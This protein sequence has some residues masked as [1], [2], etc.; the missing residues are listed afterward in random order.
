MVEASRTAVVGD[1]AR[2]VELAQLLRVELNAM[3]GGELWL[4]REAWPEPL[5]E[6]YAN[7]IDA[8][9]TLVVVGTI[10]DAII[11]YGV[12]VIETLRSSAQLGVITDLFVEPGARAV[13]IGECMALQLIAFC[14]DHGCIGIDAL[15]LPGHREAKNF[16]ER[17]GFTARAL[18]MHRRLDP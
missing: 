17:N 9:D 1:L 13:G 5:R 4:R 16:F 11:G 6:S 7:L 10:D 3:K 15:A 2:I 14:I 12:V 18:T 8:D